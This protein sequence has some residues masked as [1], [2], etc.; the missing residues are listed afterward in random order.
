M[1][2]TARDAVE[3]D[4]PLLVRLYRGLAIEQAALRPMWP[5]ADGLDEP[6]EDS[7]HAALA[8]DASEVLIGSIDGVPF[9]FLLARVERLLTQANGEPVGTI[10]LIYTEEPARGVG[11]GAAMVEEVLTRLRGR[12]LRWFDARV[13]PGHRNAKNFF[14]AHGFSA[15]LIV[16]HHDD[17][18]GEPAVAGD[19][20]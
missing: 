10:R 9:G 19:D 6:I 14:E 8:D 15:R 11:V 17:S 13:S 20:A 16:M 1:Q 4:V 7:F 12:G 2:V 3:A 5:L 18:G